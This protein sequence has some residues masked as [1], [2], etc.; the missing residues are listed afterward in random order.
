MIIIRM[1]KRFAERFLAGTKKPL[2]SGF[3]VLHVCEFLPAEDLS[4]IHI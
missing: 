4:L 2:E 1:I 3:F